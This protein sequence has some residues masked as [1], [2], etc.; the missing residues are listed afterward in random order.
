M[1]RFL[2]RRTSPAGV[3]HVGLTL[4][5]W[6]LSTAAWLFAQET[7]TAGSGEAEARGSDGLWAVRPFLREPPIMPRDRS[8]GRSNIDHW[9]LAGLELSSIPPALQASWSVR[10]RRISLGIEG[11]PLD[12]ESVRESYEQATDA[13][14]RVVDRMLASPAYGERWGRHW[15]DLARFAESFG[16]EHDLDNEFAYPYRDFV[17]R[18]F[19]RD[20]PYDIFVRWQ[21]AG[22]ELVPDVADAR[23]ATG[24][25]AT[26]VHNA[27]FAAI[28]VEQERYDELDDIVSTI[29]T[30]MLG[31]SLGCAR[32]HDHKFDAITQRDYYRLVAAFSRTIRG[33]V[34]LPTEGG[35]LRALVAGEGLAPL[36]RVYSPGPAFFPR[37]FFLERGDPAH[38]GDVLDPGVPPFLAS[39]PGAWE[40]WRKADSA[41]SERSLQRTSE[42]AVGRVAAEKS[43]AANAEEESADDERDRRSRRRAIADWISDVD[44]GAG[45]LLARVIVN[46]LWQH[47][48]GKAL[49]PTP[50]DFGAQG[51]ATLHPEL[52]DALARHLVES[53][54][55]LK[56]V[57]RR[58][59]LS[60]AYQQAS[61]I[62]PEVAV[63]DPTNRY[64]GRQSLR[65]MEAEVIR[66]SML[67]ASGLLDRTIG[68]PGTLDDSHFRRSLY[69]KVK[70]SRLPTILTIFDAPDALQGQA[71]R[72]TTT[73]ATQSL[74]L[75]NRGQVMEWS[76]ALAR[77]ARVLSNGDFRRA[78][79]VSYEL[80]LGR[81]ASAA[82]IV[83]CE[84]WR[85]ARVQSETDSDPIDLLAEICH[86]LFCLNEFVYGD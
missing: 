1:S 80:A 43:A 41:E 82:E 65:R 83:E 4:L 79:Q 69:F 8:W 12:L 11:L 22:D 17:V 3:P 46:R 20:L 55:S 58:I 72:P 10:M 21:L 39:N 81:E 53:N 31:M 26:G 42:S 64:F 67:A 76:Q 71:E 6:A 23:L 59:L 74:A 62:A 7:P 60:A 25:L 15:L 77:R 36:P 44:D 5:V 19:N 49:V 66:D 51:E 27:D 33:E 28:Q 35:M 61:R 85:R 78:V 75:L 24:F 56:Q 68:G 37:V 40:R 32:C 34:D 9:I 16:F 18:A 45:R 84:E 2:H 14:E 29:G 52:L 73:V 86:G 70:R 47:H 38:K 57:Q 13:W 63:L 48:F 54:W 50:S 30:A